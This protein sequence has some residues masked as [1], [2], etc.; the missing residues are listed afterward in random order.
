VTPRQRLAD[1]AGV[2]LIEVLVAMVI[3]AVVGVVFTGAMVQTYRVSTTVDTMAQAQAQVRLALQRLDR[4]LRYAYGITTPSTPQEAAADSGTWYVEFMG[5]DKQ[6]G[7]QEC[8]QLRLQNGHLF[9][10]QWPPGTPPSAVQGWMA[11]AS[12]IDM[13]AFATAS[14]PNGPVP[15]ELQAAGS[16]PF[17]TPTVGSQFSPQFQRL[18]LRLTTQV[19]RQHSS[20]DVTFTALNTARTDESTSGPTADDC[21]QQGRPQQ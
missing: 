5:V 11:L 6:T 20:S 12:N 1:D 7:A 8:D 18:R 9:L 13:T 10:R 19:D 15:F 4:E 14:A 21:Q 17:V 2:S 16:T 3:M